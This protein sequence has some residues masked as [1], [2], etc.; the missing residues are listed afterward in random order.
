M[1]RPRIIA[2]SPFLA[3]CR[4]RADLASGRIGRWIAITAFSILA[5][6]CS[7]VASK[8]T[9]HEQLLREVSK[10]GIGGDSLPSE[11]PIV[12]RGRPMVDLG[13][14]DRLVP[15]SKLRRAGFPGWLTKAGEGAPAVLYR[16]RAENQPFV[17]KLGTALPVTALQSS[18]SQGRRCLELYDVLETDFAKSGGR[19][20]ELA[21]NYTAQLAYLRKQ[22]KQPFLG[23][24]GLLRSDQFFEE[25][26]LYRMEPVDTSRIPVIM[27][28]GLKSSPGVWSELV[29]EVR[30]DVEV[31]KS[32]QF[33]FFSYPTGVPVL[34][35]AMRL[36]EALKAMQATYNAD[37]AHPNMSRCLVVGHSMGSLLAELQV[38]DS[39]KAFL[40]AGMSSLAAMQLSEE[41]EEV[42]RKTVFFERQPYLER[43]VFIAG[44]HHGSDAAVGQGG[45]FLS[46][47][48]RLPKT[49]TEGLVSLVTPSSEEERAWEKGRPGVLANSIDN[50]RTGSPFITALRSIP[51]PSDVPYHS[52]IADLGKRN[53]QGHSNDGFVKYRSAHLGGAKSE[54]IVRSGHSAYDAEETIAE[55]LRIMRMHLKR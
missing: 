26:G 13:E 5:T 10:S 47:L 20:V 33:W 27:V 2:D 55:V 37:G 32:Y 54:V 12:W 44:P 36:R 16:S 28:H 15:A 8:R 53:P 40:P 29:N 42:V 18:D 38:K 51:I 30:G 17:S 11:V 25:T 24:R 46:S 19:Q 3:R 35:S 43:L 6:G 9:A 14:Y 39:G 34:Y 7:L 45:R 50:M 52:V 1:A 4:R 49:V 23:L 41:N 31:R 21:A 48:I 22:N